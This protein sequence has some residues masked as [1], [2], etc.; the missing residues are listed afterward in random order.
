M[1]DKINATIKE[2]TKLTHD[3]IELESFIEYNTHRYDLKSHRLELIEKRNN[4]VDYVCM[5][6]AKND[7]KD[8]KF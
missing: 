8:Y 4:L 6:N 2:I 7:L 3:I 1:N 5:I